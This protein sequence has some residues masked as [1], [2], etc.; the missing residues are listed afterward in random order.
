MRLVQHRDDATST[1]NRLVSGNLLHSGLL[2]RSRNVVLGDAARGGALGEV[3]ENVLRQPRWKVLRHDAIVVGVGAG[4]AA[5]NL[6][7]LA[8]TSARHIGRSIQ[9]Q[10]LCPERRSVRGVR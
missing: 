8:S 4:L 9:I 7:A 3:V 6:S 1:S 5:V 2:E 10:E